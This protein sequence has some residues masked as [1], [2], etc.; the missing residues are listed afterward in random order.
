MNITTLKNE[1]LTMSSREIA[2][3]TGKRHDNVKRDVVVMLESL[4]FDALKF[5]DIYF[6]SQRRQQKEYKLDREMTLCLVSGYN[7][8]L[9]MAIIKR[10]QELESQQDPQLP[11]S[12][13]EALQLAADQAKHIEQQTQ[14]LEHQ[15][16]HIA[17]L[18]NLFHSGGTIAQFVKQL[19]GVNSNLVNA[20]LYENTN[21]LYDSN[22]GKVYQ[23]GRKAG[24][25]KPH[26]W[27]CASY[28]RDK[29]LTERTISIEKQGMESITKYKVELLAEGKKW[30][31]RKYI[32]GVLPMKANFNGKYTHEKDLT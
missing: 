29:Y 13:A 8:K 31:Y 24:Q 11:Q 16:N 5:E 30:L 32:K 14:A 9:R 6:D 26:E 2:E 15:Q 25:P 3:L 17:G 22:A 27:R 28:A 19:N 1:Q 18:E 7:V 12:F 23:S 20:W 21:W 10:W 4:D